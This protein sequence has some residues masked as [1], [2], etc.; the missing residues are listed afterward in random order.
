MITTNDKIVTIIKIKCTLILLIVKQI[1]IIKMR[2]SSQTQAHLNIGSWGLLNE[3][4][5]IEE[6]KLF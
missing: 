4:H 2:V 1:Q 5:F 6:I 3:H